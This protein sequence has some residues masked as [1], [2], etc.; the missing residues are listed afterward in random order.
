M[1]MPDHFAAACG[2][3]ATLALNGETSIWLIHMKVAVFAEQSV[4]VL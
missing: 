2:S 1:V 4:I 3:F